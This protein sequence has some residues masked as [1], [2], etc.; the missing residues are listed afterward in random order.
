MKVES[1]YLTDI[2]PHKKKSETATKS[3]SSKRADH[4]HQYERVIIKWIFG[5]KWGQRCKV[6]G[7]VDDGNSFSRSHREDFLKPEAIGKPGISNRDYLSL[8]ELHTKYPNVD[9]YEIGDRV[10]HG[11]WEYVLVEEK[12]MQEG[13]A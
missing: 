12:H 10:L 8:T 7:R 2:S 13:S 5:Y 4:K 9:I 3:K 1:Q 6:C 11:K